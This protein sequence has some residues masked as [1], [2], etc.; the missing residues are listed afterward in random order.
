[1]VTGGWHLAP[2][3]REVG[4]YV[5]DPRIGRNIFVGAACQERTSSS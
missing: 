4:K 3:L 5:E 1:M 2:H